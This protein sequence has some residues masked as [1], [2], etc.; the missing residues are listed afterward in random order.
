LPKLLERAGSGR[1]H[2]RS[3]KLCSLLVL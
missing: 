3:R 1:G 2:L